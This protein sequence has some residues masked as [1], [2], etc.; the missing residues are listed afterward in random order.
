MCKLTRITYVS[1]KMIH[2]SATN[3][4]VGLVVP[5][6]LVFPRA[7]SSLENLLFQVF[8]LGRLVPVVVVQYNYR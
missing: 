4:L 2:V 6:V 8:H 3:I 5:L 7:P 1:Y